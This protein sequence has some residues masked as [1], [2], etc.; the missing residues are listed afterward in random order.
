MEMMVTN[1]TTTIAHAS[2]CNIQGRI[3]ASAS[4]GCCAREACAT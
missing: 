3:V 4:M 1:P 2:A